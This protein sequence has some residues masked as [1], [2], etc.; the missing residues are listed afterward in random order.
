MAGEFFERVF[1]ASRREF[2]AAL[3]DFGSAVC[4]ARPK[5]GNCPLA[6]RCAYFKE[7]GRGEAKGNERKADAHR[8]AWRDAQVLLWLHENHRRYYS[9]RKTVFRPFRI[10]SA[11]N[12]RAGIKQWFRDRFGLELSVRPPHGRL[13]VGERPTLLINAQILKGASD[14]SVFA[15]QVVREYNESAGFFTR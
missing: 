12:T 10:P 8:T 15:P 1:T 5:C 11:Y 4:T 13:L 3:M 14:F 7:S 9:S 2:N 6:A